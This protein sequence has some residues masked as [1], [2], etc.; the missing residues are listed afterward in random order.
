MDALFSHSSP[1]APVLAKDYH[2]QRNFGLLWK[3]P[4][5]TLPGLGAPES[6]I[7]AARLYCLAAGQRDPRARPRIALIY[8]SGE[9]VLKD[10]I[11]SVRWFRLAAEQGSVAGQVGLTARGGG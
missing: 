10:N 7:E 4:R 5:T 9:G 8:S 6:P 2:G 1:L 11:E 3:A